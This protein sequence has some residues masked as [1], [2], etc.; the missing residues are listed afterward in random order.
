MSDF[1]AVLAHIQHGPVPTNPTMVDFDH[2]MTSA[3]NADPLTRSG[4][5]SIWHAEAVRWRRGHPGEP[6]PV[7]Q[8]SEA[9]LR[10]IRE[11]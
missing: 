6:L 1:I 7:E 8:I 11:R 4:Q 2:A 9:C 3:I 5:A 10:R